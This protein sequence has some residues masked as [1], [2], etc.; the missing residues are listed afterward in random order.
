MNVCF[1]TSTYP[2]RDGDATPA[3]VAAL[4]ERLVSEHDIGVRVVAPHHPGA[5]LRESVRGVQIERFRYA[6]PPS[7]ACLAYGSGIPDN[8]KNSRLARWQLPGFL[9][10]M[11]WATLRTAPACDLVHAHWVEPGFLATS[12]RH[13]HRRP[14]V[15]TVHSMNAVRTRAPLYR[16]ALRSADQV[17]FNSRF[18]LQQAAD[19]GFTCRARVAYQ[20]FDEGLFRVQ[21]PRGAARRFLC[22]PPNAPLVVALG[23]LVPFKGMKVLAA[24]ANTI[25]S[26]RPDAH[27]VIAGDGP[28]RSEI[29]A[30]IATCPWGNR[31]HLPGALDKARVRQ[32]LA[33]ADLFVMPSVVNPDGKTEALGVT[34]LEAMASG[35]PCVGS[36]V[37]GI[38]ET[39]AENETGL[40]VA[41]GDSTELA[42]AIGQLLDAPSLRARLGQAGRERAWRN[43]SWSSLARQVAATYHEVLDA[44]RRRSIR[45]LGMT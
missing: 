7:S 4:A 21:P 43:F 19:A 2:L 31:V 33:D 25:L 38:V 26:S 28:S 39:I 1:V 8:L 32:L 29:E 6:V 34:A 13:V 23:R 17:L 20:G 42:A 30:M 36:R 44:R 18:T 11:T 27:I 15:V 35:L 22:V 5:P 45:T 37:G 12:T 10:A 14:V 16:R 9:A 3:F 41:P 24:A 40:L